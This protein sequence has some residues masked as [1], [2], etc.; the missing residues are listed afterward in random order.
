[1]Q[2]RNAERKKERSIY[3]FVFLVSVCFSLPY[4]NRFATDV[5]GW[6]I[7]CA[8]LVIRGKVPYRDFFYYMPPAFLLKLCVT[9]LLAGRKLLWLRVIGVAERGILISLIY[10]LLK[11]ITKPI[12]AFLGSYFSLMCILIVS[13]DTFGDYTQFSWLW[14]VLSLVCTVEFVQ[15]NTAGFA[16]YMKLG[17]AYFLAAQ[18]VMTKQS[19][20]VVYIAAL[21]LWTVIYLF[22]S[23]TKVVK[24]IL[25]A[26][27]GLITGIVPWVLWLAYTNSFRAF[28]DQVFL[29]AVNS[30]GIS[31]SSGIENSIIVRLLSAIFEWPY[32]LVAIAAIAFI[33]ILDFNINKGKKQILAKLF[34]GL[35]II[36]AILFICV[37]GEYQNIF[38][39]IVS[40][41]TIKI[42]IL[43]GIFIGGLLISKK[44]KHSTDKE[45]IIIAGMIISIGW[46]IAWFLSEKEIESIYSSSTILTKGFG[47]YLHVAVIFSLVLCLRFVLLGITKRVTE[48]NWVE[49]VIIVGGLSITVGV[50]MGNGTQSFSSGGA[51]LLGAVM[52]CHLANHFENAQIQVVQNEHVWQYAITQKVIL[53]ISVCI[54]ILT[55]F[56]GM[57]R[58]IDSPYTWWG[59]ATDCITSS[60]SYTI[61]DELYDGMYV[62]KKSKTYLEE[63]RNLI[64]MNTDEDDF[65]FSFPYSVIYNIESERY[66]TLTFTPVYFF[67]VCPDSRAQTD[68]EILKVNPPKI[69]IWKDLGENCW[70]THEQLYRGGGRLGQRDI[71]DWYNEVCINGTQYIQ[72]GEINNQAIWMLNDGSPVKYTYFAEADDLVSDVSEVADNVVEKNYAYIALLKL[73]VN[74]NQIQIVYFAIIIIALAYLGFVIATAVEFWQIAAAGISL[75]FTLV[76]CNPIV[77]ILYIFPAFS[78]AYSDKDRK[79]KTWDKTIISLLLV[80]PA[81]LFFSSWYAIWDTTKILVFVDI[82]VLNTILFVKGMAYA[83]QNKRSRSMLIR[84]VFGIILA[85]ICAVLFFNYQKQ[86]DYLQADTQLL[87]ET[88]LQIFDAKESNRSAYLALKKARED[89]DSILPDLSSGGESFSDFCD[90][91]QNLGY[92]EWTGELEFQSSALKDFDAECF[93]IRISGTKV[94]C[95][96]QEKTYGTANSG[97][98]Y[99]YKGVT[100]I[101]S[102]DTMDDQLRALYYEGEEADLE[103]LAQLYVKLD[104]FMQTDEFQELVETRKANKTI[105][106]ELGGSGESWSSFVKALK[107]LKLSNEL[108]TKLQFTSSALNTLDEDNAYIRISGTT[109]TI[110]MQTSTEVGN[111]GK[112]IT[113]LFEKMLV[114]NTSEK[115]KVLYLEAEEADYEILLGMY[116][117]LLD[118]IRSSKFRKLEKTVQKDALL[119]PEL[120]DAGENLT[121]FINAL[122]TI[123]LSIDLKNDIDFVSTKLK[124]KDTDNIFIKIREEEI[125]LWIQKDTEIGNSGTAIQGNQITFKIPL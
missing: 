92:E 38:E 48:K 40:A 23:K 106:E 37:F 113:S 107:K 122:E 24:S 104:E 120:Y 117:K 46:V 15:D 94:T 68:L 2:S 63:I 121:D 54:L 88:Y 66:N 60:D 110:W 59:W 93:Y 70:T 116:D 71:Q 5:T 56:I 43:L 51:F 20:G 83:I 13:F 82:I 26:C 7:Y 81:A 52:F 14:I 39:L 76:K 95:W 119:L 84:I 86:E 99:T 44:F 49:F 73:G 79:K 101:Y 45:N 27:G 64:V 34:L 3:L 123:D 80:I 102:V 105:L 35:E 115:V 100:Y 103:Y 75:L 4:V 65:V 32:Q 41:D 114:T 58:K 85:A 53:V 29:E 108:P 16:R 72:I 21:C 8:E 30:K 91:M 50:L 74:E 118:F 62:S 97:R 109:I 11:K 12:Y 77:L 33:I 78:V 125:V 55:S 31:T 61:D 17:L 18:A 47:V 1:M 89:D 10:Y 22:L 25:A 36:V 9:W 67:D 111:S 124:G 90:V 42:V 96:L 6:N 28:V 19:V 69:I 57:V 87:E 98:A 112:A